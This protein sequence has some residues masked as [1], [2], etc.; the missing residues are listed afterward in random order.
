MYVLAYFSQ[1]L[2][3]LLSCSYIVIPLNLPLHLKWLAGRYVCNL[4][5]HTSH[6]AQYLMP[7]CLILIVHHLVY[8][9]HYE[10]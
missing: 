7:V 9:L 2:F 3:A 10:L 4:Q 5:V 6:S 1:F 8:T